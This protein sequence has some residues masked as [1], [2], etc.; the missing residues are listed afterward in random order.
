MTHRILTVI[1]ALLLVLGICVPGLQ[2][3]SAGTTDASLR[4][5]VASNYPGDAPQYTLTF[6]LGTSVA[7]GS[8]LAFT[9]DDAVGHPEG[10]TISNSLISV[11]GAP[12]GKNAGWQGTTLTLTV[13][14][15]LAAGTEHTV[16]IQEDAGIQNPWTTGHYRITLDQAAGGTTLVSNYYSVTTVTHLLPLAFD[17]IV[18]YDRLTGVRITFKTGRNGALVGHDPI[19]ID[20]QGRPIYPTTEDTMTL[21]LSA[22]LSTLWTKDGLVKLL[23]AYA[24]SPFTMTVL[25]SIVY[26]TNDAGID[27]RQLVL[28]LPHNLPANTQMSLSLMFAT[29][30]DASAVSDADY[31]KFTTSK[32]PTLVMV[33]PQTT[34][35]GSGSQPG[36]TT[37]ADTTAPT[38]TWTSTASTLLPRLVTL[39]ITVTE[40]HLDEAWFSGGTDSFIHTR[41]STGDNTIMVINRTGIHGSIVATDQAG[42]TTTVPVD[43]PASSGT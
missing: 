41:L 34:S 9:F 2:A 29:T 31:V 16:I 4:V 12:L 42:N 10:T 3:V 39:H 23:P 1:L 11:D 17:K 38:V 15:D 30:Q 35:S 33:P 18:E 6:T 27:Q 14:Q 20:S 5:D 21:R 24:E 8:T 32:E 43:L 7:A 40:D 19:R 25:S 22:G 37:T 26:A 36:D 28:N 13:P